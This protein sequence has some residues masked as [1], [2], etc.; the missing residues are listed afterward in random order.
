LFQQAPPPNPFQQAFGGG[1]G[2][3]G[4]GGLGGGGLGGFGQRPQADLTR[5]SL[6]G[7]GN[8]AAAAQASQIRQRGLAGGSD[9][10]DTEFAVASAQGQNEQG[11][12]DSIA[13]NDIQ[14]QQ[15]GI[16]QA[17]LQQR[18]AQSFAQ[19]GGFF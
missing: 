7:R 5:N 6:I 19:S 18:L 2:G 14:N 11:R 1:G 3:L 9:A 13:N 17:D 10:A 4:G 8:R 15:L 12:R 16:Q